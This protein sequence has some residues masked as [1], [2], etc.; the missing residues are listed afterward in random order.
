[1]QVQCATDLSSNLIILQLICTAIYRSYLKP[2][3]TLMAKE[4]HDTERQKRQIWV[5][6]GR[7]RGMCHG[8]YRDYKRAKM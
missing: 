5:A 6:E 8:Y 4:L 2:E 3:W 7:P 1:M